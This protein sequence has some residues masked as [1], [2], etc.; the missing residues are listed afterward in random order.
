MD[1]TGKEIAI[2]RYDGQG[3]AFLN[4]EEW[5]LKMRKEQGFVG[6]DKEAR[7]LA[8]NRIFEFLNKY[9]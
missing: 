9:L 5:A 7:D 3:H 4:D 2:Y 6:G 8:W 1:T